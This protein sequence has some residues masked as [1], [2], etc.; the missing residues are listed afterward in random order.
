MISNWSN[1]VA[2]RDL[3][4]ELTLAE[5]RSQSQETRL[6]WLFWLVDPLIMMLIYWGVVVG[7][8]GRGEQY[9]PYPVFILCAMLPWKHFTS[10][11]I[12]SAKVLR[13]RDALI[14]SIPFPTIVLP[15]TIVLAGFSNFLFGSVVLFGTAIAFDR[16][17]GISLVQLPALML[18]QLVVVGGFSLG[19]A[20]FGALIRDLTGFLGHL[21][22][23]GF[24]LSPCLYGVDMVKDRFASGSLGGFPFSE[25]IPTIYML[26]PFA[27]LFTGYREALFYG[28]MLEPEL[29]ALLVTEAVILLFGGWRLYQYFDRRVI[30]FL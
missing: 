18:L 11:V 22:R 24:Y 10:S 16:P 15:L 23:I 29:W 4:R 2:R 7:L 27:I 9:T 19:V 6:G 21:T 12:A 8:F 17:L 1:L 30:K 5:L 3:L 13:S 14:K 20:C 28:R 25:W 26:N